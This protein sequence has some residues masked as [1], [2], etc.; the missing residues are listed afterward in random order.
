MSRTKGDEHEGVADILLTLAAHRPP[1]SKET[2]DDF[3]NYCL[4]ALA[5]GNLRYTPT[6]ATTP[7]PIRDNFAR[8][9]FDFD[10]KE[11]KK[12]ASGAYYKFL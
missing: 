1:Q 5:K 10:Y 12:S 4:S 7:G 9:H 8:G 2:V 11:P 3:L 6:A